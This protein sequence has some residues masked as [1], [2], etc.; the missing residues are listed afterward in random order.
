MPASCQVVVRGGKVVLPGG[1]RQLDVGISEGMIAA[2]ADPG[3]VDADEI[4]DARDLL[5]IP[6][7]IDMHVHFREPGLTEN[8]DF[9]HGT[10]AAACGGVTCI[11]DMPNTLPPTTDAARLIEKA[12]G[13]ARTAYV[14][15]GL[16]AGGIDTTKQAILA[17]LGAVGLK[18]YMVRAQSDELYVPDDATLVDVLQTARELD[19]PICVHVGDEQL[20]AA[21][22]DAIR[23]RGGATPA[24][25]LEWYRGYAPLGGLVRVLGA[26]WQT[27]AR[28][29]IA[30]ASPYDPR[31]FELIELFRCRGTAVTVEVDPP[32]L[33][34]E[35][36]AR[37]G[38]RALPFVL[39]KKEQL[40]QWQ[41]IRDGVVDVL[42]TDH[43]P[44]SPP[45]LAASAD[46]WSLRTGFPA[47]ETLLPLAFDAVLR[48]RLSLG[49]MVEL[50][51]QTPARILRL[52]GKGDLSPGN[53]ADFVLLDP[54]RTWVV[55]ERRLHSKSGWS[56]FHGMRLRGLVWKTFLR[57]RLIAE[58][59]EVVDAE[60]SG[61]WLRPRCAGGSDTA[62]LR[63][64]RW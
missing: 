14:D 17:E 3:T 15:F 2:L 10:A 54:A 33:D 45:P 63:V 22:R 16:W 25:Y 1:I 28:V 42:A 62:A 50:L 53:D 30:H 23:R 61:R 36:L 8:E 11:C 34:L 24:D 7:A 43:S 27:G 49:R 35:D 48:E 18:L 37:L 12:G 59:G 6:G 64:S 31:C 5:V 29:H 55:D 51:S 38:A 41:R 58:E 40:R 13:V 39:S 52:P 47:V 19:W 44:H 20:A 4:V 46:V 60:P 26:A 56:P 9:S 32:R 57:G 21:E